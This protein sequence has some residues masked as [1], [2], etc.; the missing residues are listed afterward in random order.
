MS[1]QPIDAT[2]TTAWQELSAH[3]STLSPDLRGWFAADP[4]R[5]TRLTL[6]NRVGDSGYSTERAFAT[7]NRCRRSNP[8]TTDP[9]AAN[10]SPSGLRAPPSSNAGSSRMHTNML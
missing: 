2:T 9:N 1:T 6:T 5:A 7:N 8:S 4:E 3:E 10:P